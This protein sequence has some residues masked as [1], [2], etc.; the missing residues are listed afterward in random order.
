MEIYDNV[1]VRQDEDAVWTNPFHYEGDVC[2]SEIAVMIT[3]E[4]SVIYGD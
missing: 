3:A 4:P 1:E 2:P